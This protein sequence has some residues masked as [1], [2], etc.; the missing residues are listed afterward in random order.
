MARVPA[1]KHSTARKIYEWYESHKEDH[2]EHLGASLIGHPCDRYLWLTFHWA[3]SP[4][5]E[6]RLLRLFE[7]GKLEE[8]RVYQNLR[9]I[10]VELHTEDEGKQ[11]QC[12]DDTGHFGGSVDGI[13]KGFSEAPETWAVVEIKTMN[14]NAFKSLV[15]DGVELSKPQH[16]AQMQTYM[17]LLKLTRSMYIAVNKNTDDLHTQWVHFNKEHFET[18]LQRAS[19]I[20]IATQPM[21]KL[22]EDPAH[23]QCKT[24]D[25]YRLCHQQETAEFNCRTCCH[26]TTIGEGQ[27]RCEIKARSLSVKEQRDGCDNHLFLPALVHAEAVD[28]G[29]NYVE[30]LDKVSGKTFR[31][32]PGY[33]TSKNFDADKAAALG[34]SKQVPFS[35]QIPF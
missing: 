11:I 17:G 19:K 3:A 4:R 26:A 27:W 22:S 30:Y 8:P 23:W 2:R 32:G 6:G 1:A 9:A 25:M 24:C 13:G 28:G 12:R 31:N 18:R 20:V 16:Y 21:P 7:T 5:F 34:V 33:V 14:D 35:D 15:K 10:G 29:N